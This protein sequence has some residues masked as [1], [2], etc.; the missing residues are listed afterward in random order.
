MFK[1]LRAN[2]RPVAKHVP[3]R[4]GVVKFVPRSAALGVV[5]AQHAEPAASRGGGTAMRG[6]CRVV[7]VR[8]IRAPSTPHTF[9]L[10]VLLIFRQHM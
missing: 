10:E 9:V 3:K 5:P 2:Q 8:S 1:N 4:Y 6:R 7:T